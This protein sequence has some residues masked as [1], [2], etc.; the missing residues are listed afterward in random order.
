[1][2]GDRPSKNLSLYVRP[3]IAGCVHLSKFDGNYVIESA[4]HN[5]GFTYTEKFGS[6]TGMTPEA[7]A[8]QQVSKFRVQSKKRGEALS[9]Y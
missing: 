8:G 2:I 1:M 6:D 4:A 5:F 9:P 3:D 7:H